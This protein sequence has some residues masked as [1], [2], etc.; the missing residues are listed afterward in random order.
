M[1][2]CRKCGREISPSREECEECS[3]EQRAKQPAEFAENHEWLNASNYYSE[4]VEEQR[5]YRKRNWRKVFITFI[6]I[7]LFIGFAT[8]LWLYL[9]KVTSAQHVVQEF[10]EAIN[11]E[12]ANKLV[13]LITFDHVKQTFNEGQAKLMID[14]Y[15]NN[16]DQFVSTLSYL[17]S[18]S[19]KKEEGTDSEYALHLQDQGSQWLVFDQ[20]ALALDPVS[21]EVSSNVKNVSL[22]L[23]GDEVG[24]LVGDS[25]Y[26]LAGLTPGGH[27]VKGIADVDGNQH[28]EIISINTYETSD[29]IQLTFENVNP[30]VTAESLSKSLEKDLKKAIAEHVE[31]YIAAYESKDIAEFKRMK[32]EEYLESAQ[33]HIED[34][35]AMG[36]NFAGEVT[37]IVYD[38]GSMKLTSGEEE[39]PFTS[40]LY[41]S[42]TFNSGYYH[43]DEEPSDMVKEEET[44][45][46]NYNL[47]YDGAEAMWFI[48]SG[49]PVS[50]METE[51]TEVV[52]F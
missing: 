6:S 1:G 4:H 16:S 35:E 20:Y 14:Y 45:I 25:I 40:S 2:E 10:E 34:L 30:D 42:F 22:F 18:A 43:D 15:H 24:T 26:E 32:S 27:I 5:S 41:V 44:F 29:P 31:Q 46:W 28:E 3:S 47:T 12:N 49:K 51:E 13:D 8:T 7:A 37:E 17:R 19:G 48:T 21:V 39:R 36:E 38:T 9:S 33:N 52:E 11:E 23:D 50:S